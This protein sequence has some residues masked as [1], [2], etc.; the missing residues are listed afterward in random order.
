MKSQ[1]TIFPLA[2]S[3]NLTAP[4]YVP[5]G[6]TALLDAIGKTINSLKARIKALPEAARPDQVTFAIFS[7]GEENSSHH[8]TRRDIAGKI[9][10]RQA[11]LRYF[12]APDLK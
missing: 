10:G 4:T 3:A 2:K 1:P 6:S 7:E 11:T 12:T 5:R 8:Y 9:R